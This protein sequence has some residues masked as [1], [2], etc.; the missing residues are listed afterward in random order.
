MTPVAGADYLETEVMTATPQRLQLMLLEAA[1]RF[2]SQARAA[3]EQQDAQA[4]FLPILRAQRVMSE[5]L[6]GLKPEPQEELVRRVAGVYLFVYRSLIAANL[7]HSIARLDDALRVLNFERDTWRE[8]CQQLA[9]ETH[10]AGAG[11]SLG[12]SFEA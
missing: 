5:L 8:V 12:T 4:A 11:L 1:I 3:L 2:S 9:T 10:F 6:I 7:E